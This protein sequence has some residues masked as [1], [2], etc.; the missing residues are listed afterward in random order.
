MTIIVG[1]T[2]GIGSGKTTFSDQVLKRGLNLLDSDKVVGGLY[3]KPTSGF[4]KHLNQI[5]LGGAV[6]GKK[7]NKKYIASII[8]NNNK[9]KTKLQNYIFKFVRKQRSLFLRNEIRKKTKIIFLDVPLLF[10]NN[11]SKEFDILISIVSTKKN[12]YK[13]LKKYRNMNKDLFN[14]IV[15]S[16]TTDVER[17]LNSD[18]IIYNDKSMKDY[19]HKINTVLNKIVL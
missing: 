7:I 3:K 4:L 2:G 12:R 6:K 17:K 13:R 9:V 10:E 11:L 16:Q 18:I 1:I 8:F 14:K 19:L 15:I 5:G